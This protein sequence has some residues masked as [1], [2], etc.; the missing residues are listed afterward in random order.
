[1][2][3]DN[4][5]VTA[6]WLLDIETLNKSENFL[7]KVKKLYQT[8]WFSQQTASWNNHYQPEFTEVLTRRGYGFAFNL[9]PE[10][11]LLTEK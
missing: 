5:L 8:K 4:T 1:M 7:Q 10:S 6:S 3:C 2:M 9:L 11:K